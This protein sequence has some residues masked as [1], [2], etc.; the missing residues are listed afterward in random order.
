MVREDETIST[1]RELSVRSGI[2]CLE[3]VWVTRRTATTV[4]S[5]GITETR[6]CQS[7]PVR[8]RAGASSRHSLT[9]SHALLLILWTARLKEE[10]G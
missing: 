6:N 4:E 10:G 2:E 1:G 8:C 3:A 9:L 5:N 7:C